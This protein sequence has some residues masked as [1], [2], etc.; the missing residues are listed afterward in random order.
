MRIIGSIP[1]AED[2]ERFSDYLLTQRIENMVEESAA[3]N[4]WT[5]WVEHDDDLDRGKSELEHFLADRTHAKYGDASTAAQKLREQQAKAKKKKRARFVD[6]RTSW[7]QAKSW[8]TPVTLTLLLLSAVVS[9][10]T[11]LGDPTHPW[12]D[13]LR[14]ASF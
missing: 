2:A 11:R 4:G 12:I 1:D 10:G 9:I 3:G 7:G 8:A 13:W 14:I 6:V 5:V